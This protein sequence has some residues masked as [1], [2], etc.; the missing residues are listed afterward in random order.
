MIIQNEMMEILI[1][2]F[3]AHKK[4]KLSPAARGDG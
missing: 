4:A 2:M 1:P 3:N